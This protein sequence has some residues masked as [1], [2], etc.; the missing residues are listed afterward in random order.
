M[1]TAVGGL[2]AKKAI[3]AAKK[4]RA[5]GRR[6]GAPRP[7]R[8]RGVAGPRRRPKRIVFS[9]NQWM[10]VQSL[11]RMVGGR[12]PAFPRGGGR[13]RRRRSPFR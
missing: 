4:R 5:R 1:V 2:L 6:P 8:A 11:M 9:E 10:F 3:G 12:A 13:R 7:A